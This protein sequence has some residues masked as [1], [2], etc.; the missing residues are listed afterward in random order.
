MNEYSSREGTPDS[1]MTSKADVN[2]AHGFPSTRPPSSASDGSN[3]AEETMYLDQLRSRIQALEYDNER[4]RALNA[5]PTSAPD[6]LH[7]KTIEQERDDAVSRVV[8]TEAMLATSQQTLEGQ[9]M[10]ITSLEEERQRLAFQLETEKLE[11]HNSLQAM[12]TKLDSAISLVETLKGSIHEQKHVIQQ[13]EANLISRETEIARLEAELK[14]S[15]TEFQTEK[16]ELGTQIDELRVAGQV[17]F[18]CNP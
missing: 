4:L 17:L 13:G 6:T 11:H 15:S 5:A 1:L 7:P 10:R 3:L 9:Q 8:S 12:Q 16:I 2:D 14:N 18:S